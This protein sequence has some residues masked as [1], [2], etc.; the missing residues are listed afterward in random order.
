MTLTALRDWRVSASLAGLVAPAVIFVFTSRSGG[1]IASTTSAG[2]R[3][4]A[5]ARGQHRSVPLI[6]IDPGHGG[7]DSGGVHYGPKGHVNFME[8]TVTLELAKRT[9]RLLRKAGYRVFLTRTTDQAVNTPPRDYNHDGLIDGI[10]EAE[11]RVVFANRHHARIFV[12]MH[13]NATSASQTHGLTLYYCPAHSFRR[14]NLRLA[15]LLDRN[16]AIQLSKAGYRP[17]NH[18]VLT[19]VSDTL[20][21]AYPE[22]P[23]F[24]QIG[25]ADRKHGIVANNAV[26]A[27]GE[28]LYITN[29]REDRLL[30]KGRILNAI[31][32]G[33]TFGI[34][35]YLGG[36][37]TVR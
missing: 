28:T 3:S 5:H 13:V 32:R 11:A 8:K 2:S 31:A 14:A 36:G 17:P 26:A 30:H 27:L 25:P 22:Y 16:I 7:S 10:D 9:A 23:W 15:R 18:G 19:D 34:E 12:S 37:Q 20:P 24:F 29:P 4:A 35:R 1:V 6:V 21:Q 33:Y